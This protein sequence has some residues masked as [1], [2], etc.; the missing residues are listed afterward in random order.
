MY[1]GHRAAYYVKAFLEGVDDPLP[2]RTPYKTRRVPV[3]QDALLGGVPARGPG[4]PRPR[5][6]PDRVPGDRVDLRRGDGQARGRALLPLR[7]RDRLGRLQRAHARGHLRHGADAARRRAQAAA[8][9]S[10]SASTVANQAHF[11]PEIADAR[12]HRLP[13][14]EPL[15][16]RDRPLP[17]RLPGRDAARRRRSSCGAPFLVAGFDDAPEPRCAARSRTASRRRGSPTSAAAR[18]TTRCRW[19]QIVVDGEDEPHP[20]ADALIV[21]LARD[22]GGGSSPPPASGCTATSSSGSRAA[23]PS[24]PEAIPFALEHGFDLLLLEATP[25]IAG[26]WPEL[27][28]A[29][30]LTVMRDAIRILRELNR[31][32]DLE[33]LYFGGVRS[34]TDAAKLIG[35]G[36]N[37][38]IVG[39]SH[40]A[41]ARRP[42][43]GRHGRRSTATSR[44]ADRAENGR[45]VPERAAGRGVDHAALHRQD[46]HP[47]PRARGPARDLGRDGARRP[48]SRSPASTRSSPS[49]CRC[50]RDEIPP[51]RPSE[52][53]VVGAGSHPALR[54][55]R[56]APAPR[57]PGLHPRAGSR[58]VLA[59]SSP[60]RG[61]GYRWQ[62]PIRSERGARSTA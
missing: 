22:R 15:A 5:R 51:L 4:V 28:G 11:Q 47:Q 19:L 55:G 24:S 17:R 37:A 46:R 60:R 27:A 14:G 50:G 1:H 9:S 32:E 20:E 42:D 52:A 39:M 57:S 8:P 61:A 31:E 23:P 44:E 18:S 38:A 12:R 45:A 7:R 35:L 41:R 43:R 59:C 30:D 29:P 26:A 49:R 3:A 21:H 48:A 53:Q 40:R 36:A 2:Y 13:A 16:A 10:R 6:E 62:R 34:G 54:L 33:L 56:V 25:G 58:I